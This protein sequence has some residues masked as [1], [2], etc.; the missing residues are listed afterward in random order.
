MMI[1]CLSNKGG[2]EHCQSRALGMKHATSHSGEKAEPGSR[3][4][5]TGWGWL[6]KFGPRAAITV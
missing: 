5:G 1:F 3:G 6:G 2:V 4:L